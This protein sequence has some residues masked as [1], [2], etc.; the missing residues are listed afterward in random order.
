MGRGRLGGERQVRRR[1]LRWAV[2]AALAAVF[3]VGV[4]ASPANAADREPSTILVRFSIPSQASGIMQAFGDRLGAQLGDGV[5]MVRLPAGTSVDA[6]VARYSGMFGVDFAEPNFIATAAALATPNDPSFP[7]QWSLTKISAVSGWSTMFPSYPTTTAG[8]TIAIVDTGVQ[9]TH[10]DLSGR[11]LAGANCLT[12][13]CAAGGSEDDNSHGTHVSGIA[14]ARTND[15]VGIAGLAL[16]SPVLPVKV[17]N[18]S[19]SGSYASIA[20]GI[21]WAV[22]HGARV[23]NMSLSGSSYSSTLCSAVSN[24]VAAGVVVV[25]AAG[26]SSYSYSAY[27]AACPGSIGVAATDS[28]DAAASYSNYG[29]PNVFL[30]A[31]GSAIYSTVAGSGYATYNGTSMA[32][33]HVA[34]LVALLQT[35]T[36]GISVSSVKT[37][38][39]T[40]SDKIGS[41][42]G[43]DPYGTCTGCTWSSAFGY[44]RIN[45]SR[46]LSGGGTPSPPPPAASPTVVTGAASG[47][48]QA[49]ATV[50]GSVNPN[51]SATTWWV[52]YGTGVPYSFQTAPQSAGSGT[53]SQ[54]VSTLLTSLGA[55]LTYHYR[56]VA[57]NAT[58][59]TY[60]G[61]ASFV[62]SSVPPPPPPASLTLA[63][64]ASVT[65]LSGSSPTG[66]ATSLAGIDGSYY[67]LRSSFF[68][69]PSWYGTF[70]VAPN[71]SDLK[72]TYSGKSSRSCSLSLA[73]YRWTTGTWVPAGSSVT[74]GTSPVT[75]S[76]A[77]PSSTIPAAELQSSGQVRVRASCS[78]IVFSLS[79]FTLSSDLL[80]LS[81]RS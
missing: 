50:G 29:S 20:A 40:T 42:Y 53:S 66:N 60:G 27:P 43:S 48:G 77:A 34:G 24:A 57:N 31:P 23:I 17:L 78:S 58:G 22:G 21:N 81:Y 18:S 37:I 69:A 9:S 7:S 3:L 56:V 49:Q 32:A 11:V 6:A 59:T 26:N 51:G 52:E 45:V 79:S 54:P 68:S 55:N 4:I 36:P 1:T 15:G 13:F 80:R 70:S 30:A 71:A 75:L 65:V 35:R 8:A 44:G 16:T 64:P 28:N 41:G 38:L 72:V 5:L 19:G 63:F 62:T 33:P 74:L 73:V 12:G 10:P 39:A 2:S 67:A 14:A 47:I 61:D 76:D 46:A 25:A